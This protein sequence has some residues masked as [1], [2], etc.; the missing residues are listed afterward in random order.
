MSNSNIEIIQREITT[1]FAETFGL[2]RE[3]IK[4]EIP[5]VELGA[6]SLLLFE[7]LDPIQKRFGI[8]LSV[9]QF[10][11]ELQTV[12]QLSEY[13]LMADKSK[14]G[15]D[16]DSAIHPQHVLTE[17]ESISDQ[18]DA[19]DI[20]HVK[21]E[22]FFQWMSR[23]ASPIESEERRKYLASFISRY[24][25]RTIQ[26]KTHSV[27]VRN[28][29]AD[30]RS[31]IGFKPSIKE[32]LYPIVCTKFEGAI[33]QDIDGNDYI[34]MTMGFGAHLFGHSPSF[35]IKEL[36]Q[37]ISNSFGLGTRHAIGLEVAE[38][39]KE[40]TGMDRVAF[41]NS[42]T[43]AVMNAVRAARALTRRNHIVL[44]SSSYHGHWDAVLAKA[45]EYDEVSVT[46]PVSVG[47][48]ENMVA[49]VSVFEF[50][51]NEAIEFLK[52]NRTRIAAVLVEPVPTRDP[53][54]CNPDYLRRLR[55]MTKD[56]GI[57]LILDEIVTGF[58]SHPAGIQGLFGVE[59]D[60]VT[61]GK[62]IGGG[63]PLGVITGRGNMLDSIDGGNWNFNDDSFP[64]AEPTFFGGTYFQH[65]LS[66][67]A[68]KATLLE[69]K[70]RGESF[71]KA[72]TQC[73]ESFVLRLNRLFLSRRVPIEARSFSS[74]FRLIHRDNM[75]LLYYNLLMRG[76][77]IWEWRCWFIS[78]AH[79]DTHLEKVYLAFV[80]SLDELEQ[81]NLLPRYS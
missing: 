2:P 13:V 60:I 15:E 1:I 61:Y 68:A 25:E 24:N 52:V 53:G 75:D 28:S 58:R 29:I 55:Q 51:S 50:G 39:I 74:F 67:A 14:A 4:L 32:L 79:D 78:D 40:I 71:T 45:S 21:K 9:R 64:A 70:R 5:L 72:L 20:P 81:N 38:L 80:D 47:I 59:A 34:D 22:R 62:T 77:Y 46:K 33:I 42:G 26:S 66:M 63:M 44:F 19:I 43:E 41:V 35:V 23:S 31:G 3:E 76:V 10:F 48:P 49:D 69:I 27:A 18:P 12:R 73:T 37:Q 16:N 7:V 11:A 36:T 57:L 6:E 54:L 65:P 30:S 56:L 17:Q 8:K